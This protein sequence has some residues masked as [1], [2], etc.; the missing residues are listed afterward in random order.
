MLD[1]AVNSRAMKNL[2][3]WSVSACRVRPE[4]GC[5]S[6]QP[7]ICSE[8]HDLTGV[9]RLAAGRIDAS[10]LAEVEHDAAVLLVVKLTPAQNVC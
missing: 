9:L 10:G 2:T 6:D 1:D 4:A 3:I 5:G 8:G 7:V